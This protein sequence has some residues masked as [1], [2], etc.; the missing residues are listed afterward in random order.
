MAE[1]LK[2]RPFA[3]W[4]IESLENIFT[5]AFYFPSENEKD[6]VIF[7]YLFDN[8]IEIPASVQEKIN[9][10]VCNTNKL[11]PDKVDIQY[12]NLA[13]EEVNLQL[14]RL[15]SVTSKQMFKDND[16]NMFS[17]KNPVVTSDLTDNDE[18]Y[19]VGFNTDNYDLTMMARYFAETWGAP[20]LK[21]KDISFMPTDPHILRSI[22]N[23]LFAY[24][25]DNMPSSIT[26][27]PALS[28]YRNMIYSG[29][30]IDACKVND[31]LGKIALKRIEAMLGY[32]IVEFEGLNG[33]GEVDP[34]RIAEL[35]AYNLSDC[36]KLA[37]A[38]KEKTLKSSFDI[39]RS[40]INSYNDIVF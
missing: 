34:S 23:T 17:V 40:I 19:Y 27:E 2:T 31:K 33:K 13:N 28:I 4:D 20:T 3:F 38:W 11:N 5:I 35:F 8:G 22:N 7:Y 9:V 30:F 14:L 10:E 6:K 26:Q 16:T 24:F 39:K 32:D 25:K 36:M 18:P 15:F 37:M 12:L 21:S 29:K 1:I